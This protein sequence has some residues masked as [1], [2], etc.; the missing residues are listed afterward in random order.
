MRWSLEVTGTHSRGRQWRVEQPLASHEEAKLSVSCLRG[1]YQLSLNLK[2]SDAFGFT[3]RRLFL[4]TSDPVRVL[5]NAGEKLP[6]TTLATPSWAGPSRKAPAPSSQIGETRPYLPG[7][8]IRRMNWRLWAHTAQPFV[9][10]TEWQPPPLGETLW[11]LDTSVPSETSASAGEHWL[12]L[13]AAALLSAL[14]QTPRAWRLWIPSLGVNLRGDVQSIP[15][16]QKAL[17]EITCH[18]ASSLPDLP[19]RKALV[20]SGPGCPGLEV[21]LRE[22]QQKGVHLRPYLVS[23]PSAPRQAAF[24][25]RGR[26]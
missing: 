10:S 7:D 19:Q 13:R 16:A 11:V 21:F 23:G 5:P 15:L 9:R 6:L 18:T 3:V 2:L 24:N 25:N 8:D 20:V 26:L 1:Y 22:A 17:A 4:N 12:D 14:Q